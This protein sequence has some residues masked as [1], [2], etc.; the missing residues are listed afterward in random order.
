M[1]ITGLRPS[2][3]TRLLGGTTSSST[4]LPIGRF[5][6]IGIFAILALIVGLNANVQWQASL[7]LALLSCMGALALNLLMG[8]A[9]QVSIG[10][11]GLLA[12][13]G[14]ST[15][16]F[17]SIGIP[18]PLDLVGSAL[19]AGLVGLIVG[20]PALRLRGLYL[21]IATLAAHFVILFVA[22]Q[23]QNAGAGPA[24]F[25]LKPVFPGKIAQAQSTW[26]VVV[27]IAV[28]LTLL[29]VG[30]LMSGKTGRTWRLIRDHESVVSTFGIN[31][32]RWK[33]SAFVISS[34]ILGVQGSLFA[35]YLG[36]LSTDSFTLAVAVTYIA[37]VVLGGLDS[38]GGAIIGALII[39]LLPTVV[40]TLI[41]SVAGNAVSP[42]FGAYL[43]TIIYGGLILVVVVFVPKGIVGSLR[44]FVVKRAAQSG[45]RQGG[46]E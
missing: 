4:G 32:T 37:M 44:A 10:N 38:L 9:G 29:L 28:V 3:V 22:L 7:T 43:S 41:T 46:S 25:I 33:L 35:H 36:A 12:V 34:I 21:A 31:A 40:P 30:M 16:W 14:F 24:G 45:G 39:S 2:L 18:F 5:I 1:T 42:T 23:Y 8:T 11:A 27:V 13:G 15:V 19:V 17:D 20:L 26:L 6:G